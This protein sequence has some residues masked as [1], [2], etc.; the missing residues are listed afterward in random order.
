MPG[1]KAAEGKTKTLPTPI[2][3]RIKSQ[4]KRE[5]IGQEEPDGLG[6]MRAPRTAE[7]K[8][9]GGFHSACGAKTSIG[10]ETVR[11]AGQ[12]GTRIRYRTGSPDSTPLWSKPQVLLSLLDTGCSF[13]VLWAFCFLVWTLLA[14]LLQESAHRTHS[15][16]PLLVAHTRVSQRLS[17]QWGDYP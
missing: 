3:F 12:G 9:W 15:G 14:A 1:K 7:E 17:R 8:T 16:R 4:E 2:H 13:V 10:A 5:G 11:T 6:A